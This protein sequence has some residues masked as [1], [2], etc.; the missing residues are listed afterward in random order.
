MLQVVVMAF[1]HFLEGHLF[2]SSRGGTAPL[3]AIFQP[4]SI[5]AMVLELWTCVGAGKQGSP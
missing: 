4:R 3:R 2:S 5:A 1:W